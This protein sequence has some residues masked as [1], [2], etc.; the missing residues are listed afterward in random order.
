MAIHP[1]VEHDSEFV[2]SVSLAPYED[3]KALEEQYRDLVRDAIKKSRQE[4]EQKQA[5][6]Q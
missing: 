3:Q 4:A 6:R 1:V 5:D 2:G